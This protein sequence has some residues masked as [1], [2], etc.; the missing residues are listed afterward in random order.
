MKNR[1]TPLKALAVLP[2]VCA[3]SACDIGSSVSVDTGPVGSG[4][5]VI[6]IGLVL[7]AWVGAL[8]GGEG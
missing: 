6:G 4:L 5:A 2:V 7:A 3:L 1:F 8:F